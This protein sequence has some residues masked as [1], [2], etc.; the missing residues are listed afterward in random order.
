V[1]ACVTA[2]AGVSGGYGSTATRIKQFMVFPGPSPANISHFQADYPAPFVL[3]S[4]ANIDSRPTLLDLAESFRGAAIGCAKGARAEST[5]PS[6]NPDTYVR[7]QQRKCRRARGVGSRYSSLSLPG[8]GY[9]DIVVLCRRRAQAK[10]ITGVRWLYRSCRLLSGSILG[11]HHQR[12]DLDCP[13]A[14]Q[15]SGMGIL[16]VPAQSEHALL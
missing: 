4:A 5:C 9:Q 10:K 3:R 6:Y 7:A 11:N 13:A 16:R 8:D 15:P 1:R 2:C 12:T 14:G